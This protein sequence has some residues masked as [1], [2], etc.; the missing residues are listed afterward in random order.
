MSN[1]LISQNTKQTAVS[2]YFPSA[3]DWKLMLD[4]GEAS[5]KSGLLPNSIKTKEAAA[6]IALKS[7]ELDMP[8]MVGIANIHVINGKPTLS[9][10]LMQSLARRN[11]P[12]LIINIIESDNEKATIQFIRPEKGSKPFTISWTLEDAKKAELLKNPVWSKYPGAMLWSRAV[13]AG[14]RRVC[15]EAL[16]GISYTPEEMGA[17]IDSN[18]NYIETT[19]RKIS[20]EHAVGSNSV[21]SN[22]Q[23]KRLF[24]I[25]HSAGI[26]PEE[27]KKDIIKLGKESS[28]DLS[29]SEY[30][31]LCQSYI[32]GLANLNSSETYENKIQQKSKDPNNFENFSQSHVTD[33]INQSN[34]PRMVK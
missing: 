4:F 21:L 1:E 17:E 22:E 30:D 16:M 5:L 8:Y 13:S 34:D 11:L 29:K 6:V 19:S 10:E 27:V 20:K 28:K 23:L 32:K 7:R 33:Y 14:L 26:T 25:A 18:G 15:P 9:A 12:G 3:S 24:S 31:L 2:S